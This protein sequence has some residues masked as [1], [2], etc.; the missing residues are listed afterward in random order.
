MA[1]QVPQPLPR[2]FGTPGQ[3]SR[4]DVP[5]LPQGFR[6]WEREQDQHME[7]PIG[8]KEKKQASSKRYSYHAATLCLCSAPCCSC[9]PPPAL[10]SYL[11]GYTEEAPTSLAAR[12]GAGIQTAQG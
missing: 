8:E 5:P 11:P 6:E 12:A 10:A 9:G 2:G 4:R 3:A 7:K 1:A